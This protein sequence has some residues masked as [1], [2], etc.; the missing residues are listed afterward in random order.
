[1][2]QKHHIIFYLLTF[3][4]IT[5]ILLFLKF[6]YIDNLDMNPEK[7]QDSLQKFGAYAPLVLILIQFT[8]AVI[9]LL[10]S[11]LFNI[12]AGYLFGPFFGSLYSLIGMVLGSLVVFSISKRYGRKFVERL[13]DKREL[14][15]FDL[16]F[17]KKGKFVI[18]LVDNLSVFPRDTISLCAGLTK[19]TKL[20]FTILSIIGFI[21]H[22]VIFNYFGSQLSKNIFDFRILLIGAIILILSV[23]YIF[24]HKIK[25]LMVKEIRIFEERHKK[26]KSS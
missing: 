8:L 3:L 23:L 22:V 14:Q 21:P 16:F 10:P 4:I 25:G 1:M 11:A 12:A 6:G 19:L 5:P 18:I 24:R 2:K 13:V 26:K 9:S 17:K 15:H 7:I 20:K